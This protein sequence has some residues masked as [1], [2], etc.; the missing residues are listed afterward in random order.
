MLLKSFEYDGFAAPKHL[1]DLEGNV[2]TLIDSNP[3]GD[4]VFDPTPFKLVDFIE[5]S[6]VSPYDD[7]SGVSEF[8]NQTGDT[9]QSL[10]ITP[11]LDKEFNTQPLYRGNLGVNV[12]NDFYG[13]ANENKTIY[14]YPYQHNPLALNNLSSFNRIDTLSPTAEEGAPRLGQGI[15]RF[16]YGSPLNQPLMCGDNSKIKKNKFTRRFVG[17]NISGSKISSFKL[18][19]VNELQEIINNYQ[20]DNGDFVF[21]DD[22]TATGTFSNAEWVYTGVLGQFFYVP[23]TGIVSPSTSASIFIQ[24]SVRFLSENSTETELHLT[25]HKGEKSY[26]NK[27]DEL[28]IGT[29]EVDGKVPFREVDNSGTNLF[30]RQKPSISALVLKNDPRNKPTADFLLDKDR[31]FSGSNT[32][33]EREE[34]YLTDYPGQPNPNAFETFYENYEHYQIQKR[35]K[36][37]DAGPGIKRSFIA[38]GNAVT[39][40]LLTVRDPFGSSGTGNFI[41]GGYPKLD[42]DGPEGTYASN[43]SSFHNFP[44]NFGDGYFG[45]NTQNYPGAEEHGYH[46]QLSFLDK[47]PVIITNIDKENELF[48]GIGDRGLVLIP[49]NITPD[50]KKNVDFYLRKAGIITRKTIRAPRRPERGR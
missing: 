31:G 24:E 45:N 48:D 16:E 2:A 49:D 37:F 19:T 18:A 28:S 43:S 6:I 1:L 7:T 35:F 44:T 25:L 4:M 17:R 42:V 14:Q 36:V 32:S 26:S 3:L 22:N 47:A 5:S 21:S 34:V 20:A 33:F 40:N 11:E 38:D 9:G 50:I 8:L 10:P 13:N 23:S 15:F 41:P 46:F 27:N 30:T 39:D 12:D 29:F